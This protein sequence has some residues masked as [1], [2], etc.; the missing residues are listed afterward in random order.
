[1]GSGV[2]VAVWP[3]AMEKVQLGVGFCC[4]DMLQKVVP[5]SDGIGC[6]RCSMAAGD[7]EG[8]IGGGVLLQ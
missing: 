5:S 8:A 2:F 6:I 3:L 1:M 4:N 7:G